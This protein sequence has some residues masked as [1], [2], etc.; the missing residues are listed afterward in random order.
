MELPGKYSRFSI[1]LS[2]IDWT[3]FKKEFG[4]DEAENKM[5]L[6]KRNRIF[7]GGRFKPETPQNILKSTLRL[8]KGGKKKRTSNFSFSEFENGSS[9]IPDRTQRVVVKFFYSTKLKTHLL[10]LTR[11]MPQKDKKD[12]IDKPEVFGNISMEEYKERMDESC[13]KWVI[14][15][16]KKTTPA[17][18]KEMAKCFVARCEQ[19]TGHKMDW[20]AVVHTN[21][22][23]PHI[24]ILIN[25]RDQ[26]GKKFKFRP[27]LIRGGV[28]RRNVM[29][30][31][32]HMLG[33]RTD[34]EIAM[35]KEQQ[36][37]AD[38]YIPLDS[39]IEKFAS[40][41]DNMSDYSQV[42][43]NVDFYGT[44][45]GRRLAHLVD[46]KIAA[47][48]G[49]NVYLEKGWA[50]TLKALGRY[51]TFLEA[52]SHLEKTDGKD[53]RLY[54]S[55][56][57]KIQGKVRYAYMMNDEDVWNNAY[58]IED[59]NSGKAW[60]VPLFKD[61]THKLV[62][63]TVSIEPKPNQKGK[64][65]PTITVLEWG[66]NAK[67]DDASEKRNVALQSELEKEKFHTQ[68]DGGFDLY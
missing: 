46:L 34:A 51:N 64:L 39:D 66:D 13:Y 22:A 17:V 26:N 63:S 65:T 49:G 4:I 44:R 54:N 40:P 43:R 29:E 18:L 59:E 7:F 2:Q 14:S 24:H 33:E 45:L 30:I 36:L 55:D 47:I 50:D 20:Q 19:H 11:Y 32:T 31:A 67:K 21:T 25:G 58:I 16:E 9:N 12:V 5:W 37:V 27:D 68:D 61:T 56:M 38:R 57:G 15:P 8:M 41:C 1:D 35:A 53:L 28:L 60:Y 42:V 10:F 48:S 6:E 62:G 52:R 3:R 23:H